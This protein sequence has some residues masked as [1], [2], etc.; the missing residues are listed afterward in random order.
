MFLFDLPSDIYELVEEG[1]D[2]AAGFFKV[3]YAGPEVSD[4]DIGH[5]QFEEKQSVGFL[6]E[7]QVTNGA[8]GI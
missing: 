5:G 8:M 4:H 6:V 1:V 3:K 7:L 2:K